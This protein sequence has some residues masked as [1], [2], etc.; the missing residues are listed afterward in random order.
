MNDRKLKIL[1]AIIKDYIETGEPV[2]SRTIAKKYDLGISSATI[3]N[4]MSDL[5]E[6][7]YIVQPHSSSGRIP[8]DLGYRFYVDR[9]MKHMTVSD[10]NEG[11]IKEKIFTS[12]VYEVENLIIEATR[13]LSQLTELACI[14]RTPSIRKSYIR[15][16]QLMFMDSYNILAVILTDTGVIKNNVIRVLSKVEEGSINTLN[17]LVNHRIVGLTIDDMDL[18]VIKNLQNDLRGH[19]DIFNALIPAL[20]ESLKTTE[21]SKVHTEGFANIL[22][23]P[24]YSN[25]TRAK[26]FIEFIN[27]EKSVKMLLSDRDYTNDITISIG[28]ENYMEEARNCSVITATYSMKNVPLGV[29]GVVGPTRM[30]YDKVISILGEIVKELNINMDE[31]YK[32]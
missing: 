18:E 10:E 29:I 19:D 3:R 24:E 6:L 9:L 7:G 15:H 12:A 28:A 27:D 20:Y 4:E 26:E 16:I 21:T 25:V 30:Q 14:V 31:I 2:G 5:E 8:S 17:I 23:Y 13:I 1:E 11:V 32:K 22:N